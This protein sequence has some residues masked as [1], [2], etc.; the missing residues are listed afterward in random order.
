MFYPRIGL[1]WSPGYSWLVFVVWRVHSL[2]PAVQSR[3]EMNGTQL[4]FQQ[5][6]AS[7]VFVFLLLKQV[8]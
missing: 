4:M 1:S 5:A 2:A 6:E 7:A 3:A 8:L